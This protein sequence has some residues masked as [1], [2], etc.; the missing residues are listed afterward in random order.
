MNVFETDNGTDWIRV[1]SRGLPTY[2]RGEAGEASRVSAS[3][4]TPIRLF[5]SE[6]A[7]VKG[8]LGACAAACVRDGA[9]LA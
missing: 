4:Y 1:F 3:Y 6:P 9:G 5:A 2:V 7:I 8:G